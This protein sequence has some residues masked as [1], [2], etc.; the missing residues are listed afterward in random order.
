MEIVGGV[1]K[2]EM[3]KMRGLIVL[4]GTCVEGI[5]AGELSDEETLLVRVWCAKWIRAW[6]RRSQ[7]EENW[8]REELAKPIP[9][10]PAEGDAQDVQVKDEVKEDR[11]GDVG[12][13]NEVPDRERE[14]GVSGGVRDRDGDDEQMFAIS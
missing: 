12:M 14:N 8:V 3:L 4:I 5:Q 1:L 13:K 9:P 2:E 7:V 10:A 6:G 11:D